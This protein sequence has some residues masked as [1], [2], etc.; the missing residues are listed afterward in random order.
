VLRLSPSHIPW[1]RELL[2]GSLV[3]VGSLI[4]MG[5]DFS[6]LHPY[7]FPH[8]A[9]FVYPE[10]ESSGFVRNAD[11]HLPDI[12]VSHP[13]YRNFYF[14]VFTRKFCT[15]TNDGRILHVEVQACPMC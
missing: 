1:K 2:L 14:L 3:R 8:S 13:V 12:M 7:H 9:Y 11:T 10:D 5:P 4:S 6:S 15:N